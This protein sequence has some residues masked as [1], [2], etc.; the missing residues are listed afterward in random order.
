ML[1]QIDEPYADLSNINWSSA[2][3]AAVTDGSKAIINLK[4]GSEWNEVLSADNNGKLGNPIVIKKYG[5]G[6]DPIINGTGNNHAVNFKAM[7]HIT[8]S[9]V[10]AKGGNAYNWRCGGCGYVTFN[11]ITSTDGA[12]GFLVHNGAT[13]IEIN[14]FTSSGEWSTS[15]VLDAGLQASSNIAFNNIS[16]DHTI[17]VKN[18]TNARFNGIRYTGTPFN[19]FVAHTDFDGSL[20]VNDMEFDAGGIGY[21]GIFVTDATGGVLIFTDITIKNTDEQ[22]VFLV[23]TGLL[24][25][26]SK[27]ENISLQNCNKG[28]T[29]NNSTNFGISGFAIVGTVQG[30]DIFLDGM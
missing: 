16:I 4:A 1:M 15:I 21:R 23:D 26:G 29:I 11:N 7:Q 18:S 14:G 5:A 30:P 13:N 28:F 27:F 24:G 8:I 19:A 20:I 2:N 12:E 9:D 10:N 22:G 6:V 3:S 17:L 25:D